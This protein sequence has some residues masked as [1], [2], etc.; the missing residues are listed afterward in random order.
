MAINK[1]PKCSPYALPD[2]SLQRERLNIGNLSEFIDELCRIF[3]IPRRDLT[4]RWRDRK[5]VAIRQLFFY[6]ARTNT[7]AGLHQLGVML[8]KDHSTVIHSVRKAQN[9]LDTNDP[10]F[11]GLLEQYLKESKPHLL[12][13]QFVSKPVNTEVA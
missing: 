6:I 8:D 10:M 2:L 11:M 3:E 1:V 13:K 4:G 7:G 12:P 9:Y 5:M